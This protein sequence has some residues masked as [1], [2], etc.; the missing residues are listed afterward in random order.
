MSPALLFGAFSFADPSLGPYKRTRF[1][2]MIKNRHKEKSMALRTVLADMADGVVGIF[3]GPSAENN[4]FA[5]DGRVPLRK[6]LPFGLQHVFAMF[7]ANVTPLLLVFS[8]LGFNASSDLAI[9]AMMAALFMAGIGTMLQLFIGARLPL[10]IGTSFTYVPVFM[11]IASDVL[12]GGG[13][14]EQAYYTILG[15]CV[16]GGLAVAF[17][18]L[19]YRHWSRLIKP[20]VP[21]IVVLS[22]GFSLLRSGAEDFFGGAEVLAAVDASWMAN[23]VPYF[24]YILVAAATMAAAILWLIAVPGIYKHLNII[25]GIVIGYAIAC[26]VP[27]MV[28]FSVL[29]V[30]SLAGPHGIVGSPSFIDFGQ[31]RFEFVPCLMTSICYLAS[32]IEAIG[33]TASLAK[34]SLGR[35]VTAREET[36]CLVLN[37]FDS[38]LTACFGA[39]P[40]TTYAEN[41][42]LIEQTGIV[43]RFAVFCGACF[44][45][46]AGFFPPIANLIYT[47]PPCVIGGTMAI[48]FGSIAVAGMKMI[49][50]VGW[51]AKNTLIV[52][53]ACA[54]GFGTSI[55]EPLV[56]GSLVIGGSVSQGALDRMG[57]SYLAGLL[58]NCVID[59]SFI[60]FVLSWALPEGMSLKKPKGHKDRH[61]A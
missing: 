16:A 14:A 36:G 23:G 60:A 53:I 28:D 31:L 55:L 57:L 11:T 54:L 39:F 6:A 45:V 46:I 48:L 9:N 7:A 1:F 8:Y 37:G 42:G 27:G 25:A 35:T 56:S 21:A 20:I 22:I 32:C 50:D 40:Q 58:G 29:S 59:M 30:S 43:S 19:F 2:C 13:T 12:A 38:A 33:D 17:F 47:I 52:S 44:L 41:I 3:K 26:C 51:T 18:S 15:S 24:C 61:I 5:T 10:V 4:L 34:T 49:A